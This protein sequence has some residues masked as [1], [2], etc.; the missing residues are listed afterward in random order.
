GRE[1]D[2]VAA[3]D[4]RRT[5]NPDSVLYEDRHGVRD[6]PVPVDADQ[7][8]S[9]PIAVVGADR[10][11]GVELAAGAAVDVV[12]DVALAAVEELALDVADEHPVDT[13]LGRDRLE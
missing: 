8:E 10:A 5:L 13:G 12:R 4:A 7:P 2:V 11:A 9:V 3:R 6:D 1:L